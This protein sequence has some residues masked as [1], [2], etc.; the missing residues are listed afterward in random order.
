MKLSFRNL[1]KNVSTRSQRSLKAIKK[2]PDNTKQPIL[3]PVTT[4]LQIWVIPGKI[5]R[6]LDTPTSLLNT[7][8]TPI[9]HMQIQQFLPR[10][11][12]TLNNPEPTE[13]REQRTSVRIQRA[14]MLLIPTQK[15][16]HK[17]IRTNKTIK[18]RTHN[19]I[20]QT[21]PPTLQPDNPKPKIDV[22]QI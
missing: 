4:L 19:T 11:L 22:K 5:Q 13:K 15:L 3:S 8:T 14:Q 7:V 17:I 18:L 16:T 6:Q 20:R 1:P 9:L 2:L 10:H 21:P 12:Q